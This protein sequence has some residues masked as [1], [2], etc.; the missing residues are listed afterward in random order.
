MSRI[1][2]NI[3]AV[4]AAFV[5]NTLL[6]FLQIKLITR[7]LSQAAVGEYSATVAMGAIISALAQAG[8]PT[9]VLRFTA[10]YDALEAPGRIG[11]LLVL[12]WGVVLGLS[13]LLL[14][15]EAGLAPSLLPRLYD[16]PPAAANVLLATAV[17]VAMALRQVTYA[18]FDGLRRMSYPA[19]LENLNV[20]AITLAIAIAGDQLS[21]SF[22]LTLSL[23]SGLATFLL[24]TVLLLRLLSQSRPA[25]R[26][27]VETNSLLTDISPFWWGAALGGLVGIGLGY[28]DKL[29]VS[30][31][32]SFQMVSIFY[33]AERITFLLK[34]LLSVPLQVSSPEITRRW[35]L[36]RR[37]ELRRDVAFL[38]KIQ[39]A[40]GVLVTSLIFVGAEAAV[41][42]VSN[43]SFMEAAGLLRVL[44][45]SI[46]LMSFYAPITTLLRAIERIQLALFSDVLWLGLYVGLGMAWM[47]RLGLMGIVL[48]QVAASGAAAI[49]NLA[50]GQ[51]VA[52]IAW[53]LPGIARV[54]ACGLVLAAPGY[55]VVRLA[56]AR[57]PALGLA[58]AFILLVA[59]NLLLVRSGAL[60]VEDR[61]RFRELAGRGRLATMLDLALFWPAQLG[62]GRSTAATPKDAASH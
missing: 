32:L 42:I 35:E 49:W 58:V 46:V 61:R 50:I 19:I 14:A 39:F 60:T 18:G 57:Q 13:L 56:G 38:I 17:F 6:T 31:F 41:L 24:A 30:L 48:A 21:V 8:L 26:M 1:A 23:I 59:Y 53:D 29:L 16:V 36:G 9:V 54:L 5:S 10:K 2:R 45:L 51:R 3:S 62:R 33:V 20:A 7:Y 27:P 34:R 15:A 25:H 22:L 47:P 37:E 12:S 11:R 43:S 52:R 44:T 28:A 40:L 55:G 4:A